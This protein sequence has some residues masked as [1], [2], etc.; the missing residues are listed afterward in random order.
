MVECIPYQL[1]E[2]VSAQLS[3]PVIEI[4]SDP[5]IDGQ[6][7]I[8]HDLDTFG[9]DCVPKF[10]NVNRKVMLGLIDLCSRGESRHLSRT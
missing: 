6:V 4:G 2:K 10:A 1:E 3:I 7:I 8:F 9:V 5:K